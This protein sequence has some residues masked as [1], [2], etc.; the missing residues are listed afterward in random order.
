M[1]NFLIHRSDGGV[2]SGQQDRSQE[3]YILKL[4]DKFNCSIYGDKRTYTLI[5]EKEDAILTIGYASMLDGSSTPKM[6]MLALETFDE[7]QII[8]LKKK[9]IGEYVL[10]VKKGGNVYVFSDFIGVRNIFYSAEGTLASSSFSLLEDLTGTRVSDFDP[11]KLNEFIAMGHSIYPCWLGHATYHRGIHW[12][13]PNEYLVIDIVRGD[14]R[15]RSTSFYFDNTKQSDISTLADDL[16]SGLHKIIARE[17]FNQLQVAAS[18]TGGH[19]S[20]LIAAIAA[21]LYP[22][23]RFRIAASPNNAHSLG[24]LRVARKLAAVGQIPLDIYWFKPGRDE[25]RFTDQTEG[26]SSDFNNTMA[27]LLDGTGAYS[28]GLGGAFGTEL[29]MPIRWKSIDEFIHVKIAKAKRALFVE[30]DFWRTFRDSLYKEFEEIK[31]HYVLKD[32]DERDYVRLFYIAAT[33]RYGSFILSAFNQK[34]LQLDP[35]AS[36]SVLELA[37]RIAPDLWGDHRLLKGNSLVQ[38]VAMAKSNPAMGRVTTYGYNRPMLPLS[39][40]TFPL[41]LAGYA[42]HILDYIVHSKLLRKGSVAKKSPMLSGGSYL[43]DGWE[44]SFLK[45]TAE[46]YG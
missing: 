24:D 20:R 3:T 7:T 36:Y 12:L 10:V 30:R 23:L 1:A 2:S 39:P 22:T 32:Y 28:L 42:C 25:S 14:L 46:K 40:R 8:D 17:E 45:R 43:S 6:L 44:S 29:F 16:L 19:D 34:G 4:G 13:R 27:P 11:Y 18:L 21:E 9:L 15:L 31:K 5:Q 33:A 35:Y 38:K 37:L 26:L 41:Y